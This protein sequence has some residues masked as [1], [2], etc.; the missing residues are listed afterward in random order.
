MLADDLS[1]QDMIGAHQPLMSCVCDLLTCADVD[2][3]RY[4]SGTLAKLCF[5]NLNN[6]AAVVE[7]H[8]ALLGLLSLC[9]CADTE[10][11]RNATAVMV[12]LA[13]QPILKECVYGLVAPL[14][15]IADFL[16]SGDSF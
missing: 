7:R 8:G 3:T 6:Q 12:Q 11:R 13:R 4:V 5:R 14:R 1:K 15:R 10:S 9:E 16:S 2:S